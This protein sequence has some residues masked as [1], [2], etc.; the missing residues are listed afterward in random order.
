M[1][2][3]LE[4]YVCEVLKTTWQAT[5]YHTPYRY[6]EALAYLTSL[7]EHHPAHISGLCQLGTCHMQ[8]NQRREAR[9]IFSQ[10]LNISP[11]HTMTLQNF[12]E[13]LSLGIY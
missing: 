2:T 13:C 4:R 3:G 1:L 6:T 9:D 10:V 5:S 7:R 11:N 12:G 8:L